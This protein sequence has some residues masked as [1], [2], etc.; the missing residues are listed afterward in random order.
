MGC[1][2]TDQA[3]RDVD[4][5]YSE[6]LLA[7]DAPVSLAD[8]LSIFSAVHM[9]EVGAFLDSTLFKI[10]S[11]KSALLVS[12]ALVD[13]NFT[14]EANGNLYLPNFRLRV[15]II[16]KQI[17][18]LIGHLLAQ[19]LLDCHLIEALP[20]VHLIALLA[21]DISSRSFAHLATGSRWEVWESK[22]WLC[23]HIVPDVVTRLAKAWEVLKNLPF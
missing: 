18:L 14:A 21:L 2:L 19:Q 22:L 11:D 15:L 4:L 23:R 17:L 3:L 6:V 16:A 12:L 5:A 7:F 13:A 10:L 20:V 8:H 9:K 1:L